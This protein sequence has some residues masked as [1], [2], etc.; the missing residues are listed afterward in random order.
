[1]AQLYD[2]ED[3]V[4]A[5]IADLLNLV[6]TP[7]PGGLMTAG[8]TQLPG[9]H[10]AYLRGRGFLYRYD[11][12]G[13]L[14]RAR[15][16]FEEAVRADPKF[17]AAYVGLA[18]MHLRAYRLQKDPALLEAA[19]NQAERARLLSPSLVSARVALG[20]ALAESQRREEAARELETAV[21]LDPRDPAAYRELGRLYSALGRFS[22]AEQ[23]YAKAIAARPGDWT[24]YSAAASF[25]AA[26]QRYEEAERHLRKAIELTPDNPAAYGNLGA[27]L[28][29]I[30]R[31]REGEALTLKAQTLN[32]TAV[33]FANLAT[34]QMMQGRYKDAV[35]MAERAAALAVQQLPREYRIWGNLGDAY[36]LA[37]AGEGKAREAWGKA[38]QIAREQAARV[39]PDP[40]DLSHLAKYEAKLGDA[41]GALEHLEAARRRAPDDPAV[42]FQ[43]GLAYAL[44]G[45]HDLSLREL[46]A[47]LDRKYPAEEVQKAPELAPLRQDPRYQQLVAQA[48][49]H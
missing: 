5:K 26:R 28:V 19:K 24:T 44:L 32:P 39:P 16:E 11:R 47:A 25:Y 40:T 13:N 7:A 2:L 37:Q 27:L 6:V 21:R 41:A 17:A 30:G 38:A 22:D 12:A 45:N 43:A 14:E 18:E 29:K 46:A 23:L 49:K 4:L 31:Q 42:R 8:A 36:W 10:D 15:Q 35:P 33:G 48:V 9:A 34:L 1:V 3:G 20:A